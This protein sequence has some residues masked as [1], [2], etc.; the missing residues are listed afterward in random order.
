MKKA[1]VAALAAMVMMLQ[2]C[3]SNQVLA[4][5]QASVAAAE[6]LVA[7]LESAGRIPAPMATQIEAAIADLP[8]AYQ[9]TTEELGSEDDPAVKTVKIADYYAESLASLKALPPQAQTYTVA[10]TASVEAFLKAMQP[11]A[12]DLRIAAAR[13]VTRGPDTLGELQGRAAVLAQRIGQL[14]GL[15]Q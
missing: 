8:A 12:K 3:S 10:V 4:A 9:R 6:V 2:G 13:A 5:L 11:G 1:I 15:Q 7:A 14:R